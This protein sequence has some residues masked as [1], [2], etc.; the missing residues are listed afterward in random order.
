MVDALHFEF[1]RNALMAGIVASIICGVIGT[2][3]VVNRLVF[4]SGGVAHSAYGGIG[5]AFFFGWPYMIG[6]VGFALVAA[7]VMAAISLRSKQR[8]DT[9]IG[10][11]WAV[12]MAA[13]SC[14]LI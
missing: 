8:A 6:A 4:L 5:L 11:M 9:I 2:L 12:G 3:I 10:V 7:L 1:M 13:V 14:F